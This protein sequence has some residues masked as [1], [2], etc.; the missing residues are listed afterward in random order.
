MKQMKEQQ[1]KNRM[2][3]SRRNREIAT[4]KKDQRKQE[5]QLKLLEAQRRQQE[6]I[7]R[8]K[9]EE[10]SALR[11]QVRPHFGQSP[12]ESPR[13]RPR[14]ETRTRQ[15]LP[16]DQRDQVFKMTLSNMECDMNRL[17]KSR[18]QTCS[19]PRTCTSPW[20]HWRRRLEALNANIDY[21]NDSISDCQANIMQM[22]EAKED[23]DTSDVTALISSCFYLKHDFSSIHFMNMAVSK[24]FR[25]GLDLGFQDRKL[26]L[27]GNWEG[28][29][30]RL[31]CTV[32]LET[33]IRRVRPGLD[34]KAELNPELEAVLGSALH[35]TGDDS[36]SDESPHS[37]SADADSLTSDLMKVCGENRSRNKTLNTHTFVFLR[38]AEE[39]PRRWSFSTQ[40]LT[41]P[42]TQR[43]SAIGRHP[44]RRRDFENIYNALSPGFSSKTPTM[45]QIKLQIP[46]GQK[47]FLSQNKPNKLPVF[48]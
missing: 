27:T 37:P 11:R 6:L 4:L 25:P 38:L 33:G 8:R 43:R 39:Q 18:P 3:E 16:W 29:C 15:D 10:V 34:Q 9:T 30:W 42:P 19:R 48:S 21:I 23:T 45:T 44:R 7:L 36:S 2:N 20:S 1:E 35:E 32:R 12:E 24:G 26:R 14:T 46:T 28:R 22:E 40:T 47:D 41:P 17:L 13:P 31:S 5:H